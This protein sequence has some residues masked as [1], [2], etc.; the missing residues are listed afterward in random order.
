M[1]S[2]GDRP[3]V[4]VVVPAYRG[5]ED[6]R[7]CLDSVLRHAPTTAT[8]FVVRAIDDA[9]PEPE[10][11]E[12][13]A[14]AEAAAGPV[15]LT[16]ERNAENLGFVRTV[17]RALREAPGDVVLLN[18][19]CEVTHGW[20]D[21]LAAVAR[22]R[23]DVASVTPLTGSGSLCTLPDAVVARFRLDADDADVD[24]CADHVAR[25]ALA[26]HPEVIAGVGFCLYVTAEALAACGGL[27][28]DTFGAGY[29]EEVDWCLRAGRLGF[30]HLVADEAFVHHRGGRSFGAARDERMALASAVLRERYRFFAPANGHERGRDPLAVPFAAVELGLAERDADRPHVLHVLHAPSTYG[31]TEKHL[32]AL[33]EG[34]AA[35]HDASILH[36]V[37]SGFLLTTRWQGPDGPV[38][39]EL[40]LPGGATRVD[41]T[42]DEVAA[43]A[44]RTA[45]DLE[46]VDAIHVH[47][48]IG[49]SLAPLDVLADVEV[50]V[51]CSVH[52]LYLA[53]PHHWLLY[54]N[55]VACGIPDE[56]SACE[57]CLADVLD[58]PLEHLDR[59]RALAA[60]AVDVVDAWVFPTR[61][62][63]D[64]LL[65][66]HDVPEDRTHV[67]EHGSLI[68]VD[69]RRRTVDEDLVL[70]APLRVAFPGRGWRKKGLHV[71]NAVADAL[72]GRGVEVHHLGELRDVAS[73][74]L[75]AHGPYRNDELPALLDELGVQVV[76]LPGPYAETFGQVM[77]E[78]LVAGRPVI[79]ARY[80]A[81]GERIRATG[82]GWTFDPED[83]GEAAA[84][85]ER[86]DRCR[87]E[88]LRAT[89]RAVATPVP[90]MDD[91]IG[92]YADL[93]A[94][95]R[96]PA[97][98]DRPGRQR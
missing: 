41:R 5:A 40:L 35:T 46:R 16:V 29:G 65:R 2:D 89:R 92:R 37:D 74:H 72:A 3:P 98:A 15:P 23:P 20:L 57:R 36:P 44:W 68:P 54:R 80:G 86:L 10:V 82:A 39:R 22:S 90:T 13:L 75:V 38:R 77:T 66:V 64:H 62:A 34:L 60:R 97:A 56:R 52:D 71:A 4:T 28:L 45:L 8:P 95:D 17:D 43:G 91:V 1:V 9:S 31:G 49:H 96:A 63:A 94:G 32:D 7:R 30:V 67:I 21:V 55:E 50:P 14:A 24:A 27:D 33:V 6:V 25:H 53:C 70:R 84:L 18:A 78:A 12:V 73:P 42:W 61:S 87:A 58:R 93:Y 19:D 11:V 76:L 88:V 59:F 81:L 79:G 85:L 26:L 48:L 51:V 47:N 69:D 83:P